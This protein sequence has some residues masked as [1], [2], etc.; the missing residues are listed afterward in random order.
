MIEQLKKHFNDL[1]SIHEGKKSSIALIDIAC[2][3]TGIW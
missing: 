2:A 1:L 3:M